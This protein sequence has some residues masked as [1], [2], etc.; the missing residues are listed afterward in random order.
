MYLHDEYY[1]SLLETVINSSTQMDIIEY[2]NERTAQDINNMVENN[3]A[4]HPFTDNIDDFNEALR[5]ANSIWDETEN[6]INSLANNTNNNNNN[7]N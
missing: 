4:G 7:N 5:R 1:Y 6:R 2:I 3:N